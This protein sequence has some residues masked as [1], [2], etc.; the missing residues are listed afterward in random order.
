MSPTNDENPNIQITCGRCGGLCSWEADRVVQ[1]IELQ[2]KCSNCGGVDEARITI[3]P[4]IKLTV[5][6]RDGASE[7]G[8]WRP[9]Q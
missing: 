6:S 7:Y 9:K 1:K 2:A 5:F 4:V 3:N 8:V